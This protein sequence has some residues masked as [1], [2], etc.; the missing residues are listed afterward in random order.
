MSP[1]VS[2]ESLTRPVVLAFFVFAGY[3]AWHF[4]FLLIGVLRNAPDGRHPHV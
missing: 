4:P 1:L 3:V 2:G